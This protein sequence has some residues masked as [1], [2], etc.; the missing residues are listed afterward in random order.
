[1]SGIAILVLVSVAMFCVLGG[2]IYTDDEGNIRCG[3]TIKNGNQEEDNQADFSNYKIDTE[4]NIF[5]LNSASTSIKDYY[6]FD[7]NNRIHTFKIRSDVNIYNIDGEKI[8][9]LKENDMIAVNEGTNGHDIY[10]WF[11]EILFKKPADGN[12]WIPA[13][14]DNSYSTPTYKSE[15]GDEGSVSNFV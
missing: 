2:I 13:A 11:V 5:V 4:Q 1:M 7:G 14:A 9:T 8:D 10:P 3:Y 6:N 15:D 12:Y